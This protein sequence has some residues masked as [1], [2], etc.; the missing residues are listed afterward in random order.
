M[1]EENLFK[2][3]TEQLNEEIQKIK[4]IAKNSIQLIRALRKEVNGRNVDY[5]NDENATVDSIFRGGRMQ[6]FIDNYVS[7]EL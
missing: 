3:Q 2:I 1:N 5:F 6:N 4:W 7:T